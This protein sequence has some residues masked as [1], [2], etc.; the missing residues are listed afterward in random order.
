MKPRSGR[1]KRLAHPMD[2]KNTGS[3]QSREANRGEEFSARNF[4]MMH[5]TLV[6]SRRTVGVVGSSRYMRNY[7]RKKLRIEREKNGRSKRKRDIDPNVSL[8]RW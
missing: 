1:R 3:S 6:R 4:Y 8:V 2:L 5:G 7:Q